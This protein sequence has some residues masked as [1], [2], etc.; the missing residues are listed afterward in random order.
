MSDNLNLD[1]VRRPEPERRPPLVGAPLSV[2]RDGDTAQADNG[3]TPSALGFEGGAW[4]MP[5]RPETR[6]ETSGRVL[7]GERPR[8]R[9][10]PFSREHGYPKPVA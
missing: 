9:P 7:H 10:D 4:S 1:A 8:P 3:Q 6:A 5:G 2:P